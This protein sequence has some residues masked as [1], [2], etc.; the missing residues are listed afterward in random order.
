MDQY[1]AEL[2]QLYIFVAKERATLAQELIHALRGANV[3]R[4]DS[5]LAQMVRVVS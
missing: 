2:S 5:L 3:F 1:D 4:E